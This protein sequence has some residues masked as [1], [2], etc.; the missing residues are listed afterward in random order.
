MA[1]KLTIKQ[2][3]YVQGLFAGLS[4]REAYK[5]AYPC[6]NMS[7]AVIDVKACELS[8]NGKIKVR[9]KELTDELKNKNMVTVER[10]LAELAKVAYANG[11]DFAKVVEKEYI[12]DIKDEEGEVIDRKVHRYKT[13]E[14]IETDRLEQDKLAAIAGIKAT[15]EGIEIKTNDKIKALELMGKYLGMFTD[16]VE[17]KTVNTNINTD[18]SDLPPEA[19]EEI[20]KAQGQEEV[21]RIVGKYRK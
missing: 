7:D 2:E 17:S 16:K 6:K 15:K 4:Q 8:N 11:S 10:V 5:Q 21:M 12:E 9:L 19:L 3:K 14:V 1:D 13:V 18:I 20:A